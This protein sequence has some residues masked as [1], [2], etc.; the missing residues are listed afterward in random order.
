MVSWRKLNIPHRGILLYGGNLYRLSNTHGAALLRHSCFSGPVGM[1]CPPYSTR[2][3]KLLNVFD[4]RIF[5]REVNDDR[6]TYDV[7]R[8]PIIVQYM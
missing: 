5:D 4:L 8:F 2:G 6:S 1:V 7:P 3:F